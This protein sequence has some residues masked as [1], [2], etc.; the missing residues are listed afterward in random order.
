MS[1]TTVL[2]FDSLADPILLSERQRS[3]NLVN[4]QQTDPLYKSDNFRFDDSTAASF[5]AGMAL[6]SIDGSWIEADETFCEI[7]GYSRAAMLSQPCRDIIHPND[8]NAECFPLSRMIAEQAPTHQQEVRFLHQEGH[9]V[10][11]LLAI[12]IVRDDIGTPLCIVFQI[13]DTSRV[14]KIEEAFNSYQ[15]QQSY[16]AETQ[17]LLKGIA[18]VIL[19]RDAEGR[20]LKVL[21]TQTQNL[22]RPVNEILGRTLHETMPKHRADA[23]LDYIQQAL[24]SQ[25]AVRG[26]YSLMI[27]G[28]IVYL[29]AVFTPI[30][31]DRVLI[32]THD[33]TDFKQIESRLDIYALIAKNIAEGICLIRAS[34]GVIVYTNPKFESM[35]GYDSC[36]LIGENVSILNYSNSN[37]DAEEVAHRLLTQIEIH[38]EFSYEV[39]NITKD[40]RPFWCKATTTVLDYPEYGTVYVAVQANIT[41]EKKA[42]DNVALLDR[43]TSDMSKAEDFEA[44]LSHILREVSEVHGWIYGEAWIPDT[45]KN[46]LTCSPA[47][48]S[49]DREHEDGSSNALETFRTVSETFTFSMGTGLPGRVWQSKQPEWQFDISTQ[50]NFLRQALAKNCGI[51]GGLGVP[52]IA[53]GK[54]LAVLAFFKQQATKSDPHLI[55][56]ESAYK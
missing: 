11:M 52:L 3:E 16:Y 37:L 30:E 10:P 5:A 4:S 53:E 47:F 36:E 1:N 25:Q 42:L 24:D 43:L 31:N 14:R 9:W 29:S 18:D 6:A 51:K 44:A 40:G 45:D 34:D 26:E 12:L 7:L 27:N 17:T 35:F 28:K 21:P 32:V 55:A 19:V 49:C 50:P 15:L 8:W 46:V 33:I 20:C 22:H 54:V 41:A 13:Q 23:I 2:N 38:G 39:H 48:F 56:K